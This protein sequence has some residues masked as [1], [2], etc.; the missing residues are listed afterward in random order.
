MIENLKILLTKNPKGTILVAVVVILCGVALYLNSD[1]IPNIWPG[2]SQAQKSRNQLKTTQENLR[3][4][5]AKDKE[6]SLAI[7]NLSQ[8]IS[9]FCIP[10]RDGK[11]DTLLREKVEK[12]AVNAELKLSSLGALR[13][14]KIDDFMKSYEISLSTTASISKLVTFIKKLGRG[15]P[16]IYW[17]QYSIRPDN[18]RD[19]QNILFNGTVKMVCIES[20][21]LVKKVWGDKK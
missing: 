20:E 19:P 2:E 21:E 18:M 13:T 7:A 6:L 1:F 17:V 14:S 5:L 9:C 12:S 10:S 15:T 3:K 4:A 11:P 16:K 8:D